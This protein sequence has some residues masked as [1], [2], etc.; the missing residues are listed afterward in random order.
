MAP[1]DPLAY[2]QA[3]LAK[4]YEARRYKDA[5]G[6]PRERQPFIITL[7]RDYGALGEWIAQELSA[8]LGVPVYD[9]EIL[10]RI[11][12]QTRTDKFQVQRHDEQNHA[13]LSTL[14]H[15]LL[16]G[17]TATQQSYRRA[18]YDVVLDLARSDCILV[19]RGAHL[20]LKDRQVFRVRIVGTTA[21]CAGRVAAELGVS[22]QEAEE[23]VRDVNLTRHN[24]IQA[25]FGEHFPSS[26][27][28]HAAHF[29]LVINTDRIGVQ[30][31]VMVILMALEKAGFD[32]PAK[33]KP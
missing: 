15:S 7:S 12:K 10:D 30:G 2:L 5:K 33:V 31:A 11:A 28:E 3:I 17:T 8:C 29:D 32:F 13:T 27:L 26:T 22:Q 1:H 21:V 23:K 14:V 16:S 25:L 24:S 9:Q 20:I 19:G 18:L 4:D 6:K